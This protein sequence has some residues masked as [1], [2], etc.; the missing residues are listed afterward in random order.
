MKTLLLTIAL[1]A[2]STPSFALVI[3]ELRVSKSERKLELITQDNQVYKTYKVMLGLNAEGG[4]KTK[5]NDNKTPEGTYTLDLKN[6]HSKFH[7]AFHISYPNSRD[8]L[9]ARLHGNKP[10]GDIMLH[11][12]PNNFDEMRDWL[13]SV[14]MDKFPDEQIRANL[15][16][17]D[18]TNGCIAVTDAEIDEIFSIVDVPTKIIINP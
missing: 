17:Y 7:K 8:T 10:G 14:N 9:R 11:G 6:E 3:K 2:L 18:W 13:T 15:S 5:E 4:A 1:S 12:Y 16:N